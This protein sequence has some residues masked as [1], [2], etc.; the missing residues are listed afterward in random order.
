M[1]AGSNAL[2]TTIGKATLRLL[3]ALRKDLSWGDGEPLVI[4][5]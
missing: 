4:L 2:V 5:S 3:E 1:L